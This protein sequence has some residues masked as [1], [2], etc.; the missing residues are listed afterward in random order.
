MG[1]YQRDPQQPPE[2]SAEPA[3]AP[4]GA[5]GPAPEPEEAASKALAGALKFSF[6]FLK[7]VMVFLV[8]AYLA[9]GLFSVKFP[10]VKFKTRFGAVVPRTGNAVL[11][12]ESGLHIRWPWEEVQVVLTDEKMLP[13]A[14]EFWPQAEPTIGH[15][16][17]LNVRTDGYLIT[18]DVNIVHMKL[19]VRYR[20]PNS[21]LDVLSYK[22]K[23]KDPEQVLRRALMA[24]TCKV[25]G[26]RGVMGVIQ[27]GDLFESIREELVSRLAQFERGAGCPLGVQIIN[28]EAIETENIKN[29]TE[30]GEVKEA[31]NLAQ[32][33][34]SLK[35]QLRREG[36]GEASKTLSEARA[37]A[38]RIR[39]GARADAVRTVQLAKAD[40]QAMEEIL[41][42]YRRSADEAQVLRSM[43]LNRLMEEL[44]RIA[45]S[46]IVLYE[47]QDGSTRHLLLQH[48]LRPPTKGPT[49]QPPAK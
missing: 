19:R 43:Y 6:R 26:S 3:A 8:V 13:L 46:P 32:T 33:A 42:L 15:G 20:V 39:E 44:L 38:E 24:A 31:F 49:A 5:T 36:E 1:D 35:D 10:E 18:G 14:T 29:P 41:P 45:P 22:L 4:S 25:V 27:R 23:V 12:P 7:Y 2:A 47:P 21:A 34:E 17:G 9:M 37:L 28:V 16:V 30:P 11:Q 40:A 48:S